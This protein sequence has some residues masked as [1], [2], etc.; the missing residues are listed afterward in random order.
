MNCTALHY[1]V[2]GHLTLL[3]LTALHCTALFTIALHRYLNCQE[4]R[5]QASKKSWQHYTGN[6]KRYHCTGGSSQLSGLDSYTYINVHFATTIL[7]PNSAKFWLCALWS[8]KCATCSISVW[9]GVGSA[10]CIVCSVLVQ[11]QVH[12]QVQYVVYSLQCTVCSP[13]CQR[14]K[15]STLIQ[16]SPITFFFFSF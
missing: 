5:N 15:L 1:T 13:A 11:V 6:Y 14:Q 9:C 7:R 8:D 10:Q 2:E 3:H 12:V 4:P 16:I